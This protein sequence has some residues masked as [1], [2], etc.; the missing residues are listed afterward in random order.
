MYM[1][2]LRKLRNVFRNED[3]AVGIGT[4]II[5]IAMVLVAAVAAAVLIST[6]GTL[7]QKAMTTGKETIA[8]VSSNIEVATIVGTRSSGTA[9]NLNDLNITI[10]TSAGAGKMDLNQLVL[11]LSN[12]SSLVDSMRYNSTGTGATTFGVTALRDA[13]GS[14]TSTTPVINSG[15]LVKLTV[16]LSAAG[17][18]MAFPARQ[19]LHLELVPEFGNS[20]MIDLVTPASYGVDT[21]VNL[22]P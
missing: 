9:S 11:K 3:G 16:D 10:A 12:G 19:P 4:L 18:N 8:T 1:K 20:I 14:F 7:Q 21:V 22:Y 17:V 2:N 15:D 6:S 13:D 5:F